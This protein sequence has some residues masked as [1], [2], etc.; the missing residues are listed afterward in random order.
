MHICNTVSFFF[1][2]G[3][4][5][6]QRAWRAG[7]RSRGSFISYIAVASA[8]SLHNQPGMGVGAS[9]AFDMVNMSKLPK[10]TPACSAIY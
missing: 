3:S 2:H 7:S 1:V 10:V 4:Q 9:I 8:T 6:A 5:A